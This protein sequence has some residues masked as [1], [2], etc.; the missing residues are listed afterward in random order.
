MKI[1]LVQPFGH[2]DGHFAT[3]AKYLSRALHDAGLD[4]TVM[5]FEGLLGGEPAGGAGMKHMAVLSTTGFLAPPLRLLRGFLRIVPPLRPSVGPLETILAFGLALRRGRSQRCDVIHLLD[6]STRSLLFLAFAAV[7]RNR[8]L[9]LTL[10]GVPREHASKGWPGEFRASLKR[11]DYHL[12][13]CLLLA[14]LSASKLVATTKKVLYKRA[15][16]RNRLAFVCYA[17]EVQLT[18]AQSVFYDSVTYIP[19][20]RPELPAIPQYEARQHLGLPQ[21]GK[22]LL[23]FGANHDRKDHEVIFRAAQTLPR[24][25]KLLFAGKVLVEGGEFNDPR[26][27]AVEYGLVENTVIVDRYIPD[28][29]IPYYFCAA[30]AL[31]LSYRKGLEQH[32]G[33]LLWACQCNLP[34]IAIGEGHLGKLVSTYNLGLT[35]TPEDPASLGQAISAFFNLNEEEKETLRHSISQFVSA[36]R[37]WEQ[38]T[39]GFVELYRSLLAREDGAEAGANR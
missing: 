12:A 34:V 36:V 19:D 2:W 33:N 37:P 21:E 38:M 23:S 32:S 25:I 39:K 11:R 31:V 18:Y 5:T 10:H 3:Y 22:I 29:E 28:G 1:L 4:V 27:L 26:R 20:A 13:F 17:R 35:F 6:T 16:G 24:D 8:N 30:D 7:C 15:I 14:R 9:A